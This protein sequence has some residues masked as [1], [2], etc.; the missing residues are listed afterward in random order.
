MMTPDHLPVFLCQVDNLLRQ[1][2]DYVSI[3]DSHSQSL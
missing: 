1:D 3:T 2:L